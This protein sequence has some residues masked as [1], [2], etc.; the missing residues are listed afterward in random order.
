MLHFETPLQTG[1]V[2]TTPHARAKVP[3]RDVAAALARHERS[4]RGEPNQGGRRHGKQTSLD[5][6]RIL[7]AYRANNGTR[8][9]ILSEPDRSITRVM[10][11]EEL[12]S[13]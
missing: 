8:F 11:P 10:L 12:G 6:C 2:L 3:P 5:G 9:W 1:H 7:T 13:L 4:V